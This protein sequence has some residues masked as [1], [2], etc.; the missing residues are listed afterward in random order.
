MKMYK[1]KPGKA[2]KAG[3]GGEPGQFWTQFL[4]NLRWPGAVLVKYQV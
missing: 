2:G 3:T 4:C 1:G